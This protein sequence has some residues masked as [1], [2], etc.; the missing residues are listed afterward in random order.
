MKIKDKAF[1][2][3]KNCFLYLQLCLDI[4]KKSE[5]LTSKEINKNER[6]VR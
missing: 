3:K 1:F 4:S 6:I 5:S 2:I